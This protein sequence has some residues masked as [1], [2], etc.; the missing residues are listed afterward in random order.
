MRYKYAWSTVVNGS[1]ADWLPEGTKANFSFKAC[2]GAWLEDMMNQMDQL[3]TQ[4]K[5]VLMEAGGNNAIFYPMADA[6]LFHS[7][8]NPFNRRV[9]G[10]VYEDDDPKNPTGSCRKEIGWVR[11]RVEGDGIKD[12]VTDKI[13]KW[14]GHKAVVGN[15]ASLFLLGYAR[16]FAEGPECNEYD[17]EVFYA[18]RNETQKVVLEMRKEFNELVR[19]FAEDSLSSVLFQE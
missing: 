1:Y 5:V 15:D 14:R 3:E 17:F 7:E 2:S 19:T 18:L 12:N 4:Q 6:C 8:N 16:L 10:T 9:Y 13:H 11:S